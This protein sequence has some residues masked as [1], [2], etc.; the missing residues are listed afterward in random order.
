MFFSPTLKGDEQSPGVPEDTGNSLL[1][2]KAREP[3]DVQELFEFCHALFITLSSD[4]DKAETP[5]W[6]GTLKNFGLIFTH[7]F[8]RRPKTFSYPI[9]ILLK[10]DREQDDNRKRTEKEAD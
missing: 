3:V 2:G 8:R 1:R 4:L 7:S 9:L 6:T 10:F 5:C